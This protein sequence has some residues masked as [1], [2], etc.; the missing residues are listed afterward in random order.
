MVSNIYSE[1]V[2]YD[3]KQQT[4]YKPGCSTS[5]MPH[6]AI[7]HYAKQRPLILYNIINCNNIQTLFGQTPEN[8]FHEVGL[9]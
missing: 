9:T 4:F 8:I 1:T 6:L 5:R 7:Y 3:A 2:K